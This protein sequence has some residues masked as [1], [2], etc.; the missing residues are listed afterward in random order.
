MKRVALFL[1]LSVGC[2]L[3]HAQVPQ[4][5]NYQAI[6]RD[7]DGK[8]ITDP[9]YIKVE[10][11]NLAADTVFWIEEHSVIPTE[12]GLI[13]FVVGQGNPVSGRYNENFEDIDWISRPRYL[14][15]SI[16]YPGPTYTLMG[17]TQ[18][19]AVP[20]S[21]LA[22]NVESPLEKLGIKGT[23]SDMDEAL[24][25]VKNKDGQ[26]V[27][28]VYNEGVRIYVE[29][30][31][32]DKGVKGGF[33][34]GGF[35]TI[36]QGE[37][38]HYLF[39]SGDSIR[40]YIDST[41]VKGVK[42]GFAIGGFGQTKTL[43]EEYFRVTRDS[44]RAYIDNN[45]GKAVK[46]GFAIGGFGVVKET[47]DEYLRVTSD[48][49]KVSKS[50]LIPR[51]TMEERD[52]LPFVPGEALIIFNTTEGCMQ[53]F[54]NSVWSNIWCF[55]CAP[56]FIIQPVD[57]TIC[58]GENAVFFISATGT[59]LNY[60]WQESTDN[61]N[62]WNNI[63][64]GGST[65]AYSGA[66][67]YKL[68]LINIPVGYDSYKYRC[69]VAGPCPP[70]IIS[71][72]VTL[73]VGSTPPV[74]TF[75]PADQQ[76]SIE[77]T[78][79]F[80]IAS[81]GYGVSYIWQQS[82]DGGST[83][84]N[85]SNGGTS[86]V[87]S[88]SA[89]ST[90]SLSNVPKAYNNYKYRCI[91]S[92]LCGADVTS[93]AAT[94]TLN[95]LPAISVQPEDKLIYAGRNGTF[96]ITTSGSGFNYQWQESINGGSTWSDVTNG[97]S[98][99]GYAGANTSSLSLSNVPL[100]YN[101]YKYRCALS[102]YC[103]PDAISD[104]ATL[105]VPSVT[106]IDGNT[107]KTIGIGSQEWMAENLKTTSYRNG[108]LIGT[109]TPATLDISGEPTPKYQW[110]CGGNESNVTTYGRLYTWYAVTDS[111]NV[112]PTG[113]HVPTDAEWTTLT[114]YLGGIS[115][116]GGKLKESGTTHWNSP[117]TGATNETGFTALPGGVRG[118]SGAFSFIGILGYW[119]VATEGGAADAWD[120]YLSA[121]SGDVGR[122]SGI[123][124][125][126][127]SVRCLKD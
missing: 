72:A 68:T 19:W 112:C 108:D 21:L 109:T 94:L 15:T 54:K 63:S 111:R 53:I 81:P 74:I 30:G 123:K 10:I 31:E 120:R 34:I 122:D 89:A 84:S 1:I 50:L 126:G 85:I 88:G 35:G 71:N 119:W 102:H 100:A 25:E 24:F 57:K 41:T 56:D 87:F 115:V 103:R 27:F 70:D 106:D 26:T 80:S 110:A 118:S 98:N 51:L 44:I 76:L 127:F 29:D 77:C 39:V 124:K 46:G 20:Y 5:F 97:G 12:Y 116:A 45:P 14:K 69:V 86:P 62:T 43:P 67:G 79:D 82:T 113:W 83:W 96:S 101:N 3:I 125:T 99:P 55:N 114:D 13:S 18:I 105:S 107:Y 49:V 64:N 28:A 95:T 38:Q 48:S 121:Y 93:A 59:N 6:A 33:A 61:G 9:F 40:A 52:N 60:Q 16:K 4:G 104:A 78:V 17:T 91:A 2:I 65:P 11:Q 22:K 66:K 37:P 73:N 36:K 90:L 7:G 75:Q 58:S 92:N 42:G 47:G 23:T 32:T 8:L 117:N